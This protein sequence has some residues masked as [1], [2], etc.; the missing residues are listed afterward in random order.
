MIAVAR[1]DPEFAHRLL[2]KARTCFGSLDG[3]RCFVA[4]GRV[5]LIGE[6]TDYN[7]GFVLPAAL[8]LALVALIAPRADDRA[9]VTSIDTGPD[10][11]FGLDSII[12]LPNREWTNYVRGVVLALQNR[13]AE[14]GGFSMVVGSTIPVGSGLSSSAALEV[15]T[16]YGLSQLYG[17][18]L[19]RTDLALLCQRVENEFVGVNC[20]IM[21]QFVVANAAEGHA[22]FLDCR[23]LATDQVPIPN[24]LALIV[25]DTRHPRTLAASAYNRRRSECEAAVRAIAVEAPSVVALRDADMDLLDRARPRMSDTV[26]RRARHVIT[27]NQ[28]VL[29]SVRALRQ[30]DA[31]TF[32]RLMNASHESLRDDYEVTCEQLDTMVAICR[33]VEGVLG[34]RMTGAGFGGCTVTLARAD[35][36][37]RVRE[38]VLERYP[39]QPEGPALVYLSRATAGVREEDTKELLGL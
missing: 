35:A 8:E 27:E 32:G 16:A 38:A 7:Q 39:V 37:E 29:D 12:A 20:G 22:L 13:G 15:A 1:F 33:E 9:M 6:H 23:S 19:P 4:P 2:S 5:N 11:E 25:C 21:D 34:S 14:I 36:V 31:A 10:D 18:A 17:P 30:G 28:R 26:Y 3:V 24:D